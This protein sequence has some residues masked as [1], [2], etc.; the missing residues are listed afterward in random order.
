MAYLNFERLF[1]Y[2]ETS[3]GVIIAYRKVLVE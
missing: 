3:Y 1:L 2:M